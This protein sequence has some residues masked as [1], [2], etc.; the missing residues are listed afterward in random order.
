MRERWAPVVQ[1]SSRPY[2]FTL[3]VS[4][5]IGA[6][7]E[8]LRHYLGIGI[9]VIFGQSPAVYVSA[10]GTVAAA[11]LWFLYRGE[12]TREPLLAA[13]FALLVITWLLHWMLSRIHGDGFT[14]A[15][16]LYGPIVAALWWKTPTKTDLIAALQVTG[17]AVVITLVSTRSLE[18]LGVI[19]MLD[20]GPDFVAFER[21]NYWLPFAGTLGPESRWHGPFGHA[22]RT[23]AAA[24]FLL[25]L[26]VATKTWSRWVFGVVAVVT[27]LLASSRG[28]IIAAAGGVAVIILFSDNALTRR[29]RRSVLLIGIVVIGAIG[30]GGVL[31]RNPTLTGRTTYWQL[32]I[33]VWG[34]SPIIGSGRGGMQASELAIAG[35]NAHNI[36]LDALVKF[37]VLGTIAAMS[38]LVV[39]AVL[40][41]QAARSYL[42][43]P[44]GIG[45]T[46]L[47][48]GISEADTE[49]MMVT[50]PW[51]WLV[52][53]VS[54]AGRARELQGAPSPAL[55][56][57]R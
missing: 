9:P 26:A 43:L 5:F 11:L 55:S 49:W 8:Y 6:Y 4:F 38:A 46:Y 35:S 57:S 37:G 15:V 39:G 32:A 40:A 2:L 18:L 30:L 19:P 54:L 21:E 23:G 28:S 45:A 16:L 48:L 22:A 12:R 20:V 27:L 52:L 3:I 36:V 41:V 24:A 33:D 31:M 56:S 7:A 51:L 34:Q 10:L 13:F 25:V 14:Y 42:A 47:I 53:A 17:W 44:L 1:G 50:V 29:V